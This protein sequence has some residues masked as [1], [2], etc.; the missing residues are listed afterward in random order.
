M[1]RDDKSRVIGKITN[2][3]AGSLIVELH[4][5]SDNFTVVGFDDMHYVATLGSYL[6]VPVHAN[7]VVLEVVGLSEKDNAP[8][9]SNQGELDKVSSAKFLKTTPVG[10]ID[11]REKKFQFGVSTYPPLYADVMYARDK[12]LDCIFDVVAHTSSGDSTPDANLLRP[13]ALA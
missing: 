13:Q 7:Y 11:L 5:G 10:T 1:L 6:M 3:S 2:V 9:A 4:G 8:Y 12:D